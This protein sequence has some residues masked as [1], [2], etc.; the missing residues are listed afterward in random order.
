MATIS[1]DYKT[2]DSTANQVYIEMLSGELRKLQGSV[3]TGDGIAENLNSYTISLEVFHKTAT[4]SSSATSI[5]CSNFKDR[6]KGVPDLVVNAPTV[7][8]DPDQITNPGVFTITIP[9]G[10]T[11]GIEDMV[12]DMDEKVPVVWITVTYANANVV[13]KNRIILIIRPSV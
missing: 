5:K 12:Y 6:T 10:L 7:T 3:K 11:E 8:V 4:V 2:T 1:T 9:Q 13:R